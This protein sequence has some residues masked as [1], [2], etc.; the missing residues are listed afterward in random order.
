MCSYNRLDGDYACENKYLLTDRAEEGLEVQGIRAL[1]LG[2]RRTARRKLRR[3][4]LDHEEP[5]WIFYGDDLK[6]AVESGKVPAG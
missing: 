4:G 2:R 5:G 3:P 1:R 6:K